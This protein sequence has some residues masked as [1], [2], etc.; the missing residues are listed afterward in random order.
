MDS[1][2]LTDEGREVAN[3]VAEC[4]AEARLDGEYDKDE[5]RGFAETRGLEQL[6]NGL[7]RDI[8]SP[9]DE[10]VSGEAECVLKISTNLVGCHENLQEAKHWQELP[11]EVCE[12]LAP[13]WDHDIGWLLMPCAEIDLTSGETISRSSS[14]TER[15][16]SVSEAGYN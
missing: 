5:C 12:H 15:A 13:V 14:I 6:A 11:D 9:D 16:V 7:G 3:N 10:F 8:F 1:C 4:Y 2:A